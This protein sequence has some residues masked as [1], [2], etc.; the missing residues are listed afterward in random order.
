[1]LY[2]LDLFDKNKILVKSN[3]VAF[4]MSFPRMTLRLLFP[5]VALEARYLVMIL[6]AFELYMTFS[7]SAS[8]IGHVAHLSGM[9][10]GFIILKMWHKF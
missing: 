2:V 5:P 8:G 3:V 4:G 9:L 1:M 10:V 6:I 7:Q